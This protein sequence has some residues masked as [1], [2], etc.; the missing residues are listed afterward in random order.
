MP[1]VK[2]RFTLANG[3]TSS[4]V[5]ANTNYEFIGPNVPVIIAAAVDDAGT[6]GTD[7]ATV[8]NMNA[9]INNTELTA[10]G[11]VS[12]SVSGQ[13]FGY[14]NVSYQMNNFVTSG[15]VRNRLNVQF[16]NNSGA[17]RTID[18]AIFISQ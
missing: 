5:L 18:V 13:P 3:S 17:T 9:T 10:N 15:G 8:T 16:V 4:N 7:G 12:A 6:G 11:S 14:N 1:L 2:Q